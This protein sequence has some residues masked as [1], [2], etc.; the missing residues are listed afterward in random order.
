[1]PRSLEHRKIC[2][3]RKI[4]TNKMADKHVG[5]V[6]KPTFKKCNQRFDQVRS[7]FTRDSSLIVSGS[8]SNVY[9]F[10]RST[11]EI[12]KI[13][14]EHKHEVLTVAI[15][16]NNPLQVISCCKK[17]LMIWDYTDLTVVKTIKLKIENVTGVFIN[18]SSIDLDYV[19]FKTKESLKLKKR[20]K[21]VHS[22]VKYKIKD[23]SQE[24]I[25]KVDSRENSVAFSSCGNYM[26][27]LHRRDLILHKITTNETTN[28]QA[29]CNELVCVDIHPQNQCIATGDS[30]GRILVWYNM[31]DGVNSP[32]KHVVLHWHSMAP[33]DVI[34]SPDGLYL[35]SGGKEN[36]L[37][38][39][40]LESESKSF[41]P[42]LGSK[43]NHLFCSKDSRFIGVTMDNNMIQVISAIDHTLSSVLKFLAPVID[44]SSGLSYHKQFDSLVF[45]GSPEGQLQFY[46]PKSDKV[47]MTLDI[48]SNNVISSTK[49]NEDVFSTVIDKVAFNETGNWMATLDVRNTP[50]LPTERRLCIWKYLDNQKTF[51]LNT[52]INPPHKNDL[53][54][55]AFRPSMSS[56]K[57]SNLL[58]TASTTGELKTWVQEQIVNEEDDSVTEQWKLDSFYSVGSKTCRKA[59]FSQDGSL[60]AVLF[61][62]VVIFDPDNLSEVATL[63]WSY[64]KSDKLK[65]FC[66]CNNESSCFLIAAS[67]HNMIV[68]DL[69]TFDVAWQLEATV[70]H[71]VA[72]PFSK[73]FA[74]VVSHKKKQRYLM[75]DPS[76]PHPVI[77]V[78]ELPKDSKI[79]D[80]IFVSPPS[81]LCDEWPETGEP[82]FMT[83][84]GD[85]YCLGDLDPIR[86]N[87]FNQSRD[88]EQSTFESIFGSSRPKERSTI[89]DT[90]SHLPL[91]NPAK[92]AMRQM[93]TT[94]SHILPDVNVMCNA[95]YHSL[96]LSSNKVKLTDDETK[97]EN[98]TT[99]NDE[100]E[101]MTEEGSTINE[102][103]G[104]QVQNVV[105]ADLKLRKPKIDLLRSIL[106]GK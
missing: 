97:E 104:D 34:F 62:E 21:I 89:A 56:K 3:W 14:T 79:K 50:V 40:H 72:D 86:E 48:L 52:S 38:L 31:F 65:T 67:Q 98:S 25:S 12:D 84:T 49:E 27:C 75:F 46:Q 8:G 33:N 53:V 58:V 105:L 47:L 95:F 20:E 16:K 80:V 60:L 61:D 5:K 76:T 51:I 24:T 2:T 96:L 87:I 35:L 30:H 22:M 6:S 54:A 73:Y 59:H 102:D 106:A 77:V 91:G 55:V 82:Y 94:P 32:Q 85:I 68:W 26:V 93:L 45:N 99:I 15:N 28:H 7:I 18:S 92:A 36:V 43:I 10:H 17:K 23:G 69:K 64:K 19:Y 101:K 66:I 70:T 83:E 13:F 103:S 44:S 42:R 1:M 9:L 90:Y 88:K 41:Q 78:N 81:Q 29:P 57:E 100:D 71:L 74:A 11:G 39:W 4:K 63:S 37:V